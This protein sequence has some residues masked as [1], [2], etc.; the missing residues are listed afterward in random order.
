MDI[1]A[2][3]SVIE[4]SRYGAFD[5]M[6]AKGGSI[7]RGHWGIA[8]EAGPEI[9]HGPATVTPLSGGVNIQTSIDFDGLDAIVTHTVNGQIA[10]RE[11]HHHRQTRSYA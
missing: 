10:K 6:F 11:R 1:S 9:V 4:A 2:L 8:G 5:G 3:R 7:R